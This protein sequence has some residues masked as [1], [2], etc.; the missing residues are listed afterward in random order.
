MNRTKNF[1]FNTFYTMLNSMVVMIVGFITPRL[2]L[3]YFGSEINGLVSSISQFVSYFNLVEAGLANASIVALYK[4]IA[5]K[6]FDGIN[7]VVSATKKYYYQSGYIFTGLV[8][9]LALLYPSFA[10][11]T[12]LSNVE[13]SLLVIFI[14]ANGFLN[15]FSLAKYRALLTAAQKV[16]V[17]SNAS[18]IYTILHTVIIVSGVYFEFSILAIYFMSIFAMISR[19]SIL[20]LY[21]K[22]YFPKVDF[23]S[24][25]NFTALNKRW[26]ALILQFTGLAQRSAP[27][28]I[29]TFFLSLGEVSIFAIYNMVVTGIQGIL[30]IFTNSLASGFGDLIAREDNKLLAKTYSQFELTYLMLIAIAYTATFNL[31]LPFVNLYTQ[32]VKDIN[33]DLPIFSIIIVL[34]SFLYIIKTPQ[35]MLINAAGHFKE[36]KV[37]SFIQALIIIIGGIILVQ[38]FGLMGVLIAMCLSNLYRLIDMFFYVPKYILNINYKKSFKNYLLL[39]SIMIVSQFLISTFFDWDINSIIHWILYAIVLVIVTAIITL[40]INYLFNKGDFCQVYERIKSMK[41]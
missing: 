1:A 34:N 6:D 35:G 9:M 36:T 11:T 31:M 16:Y 32:G 8:F 15:F 38:P 23:N 10:Q 33:Y 37:Q 24:E 14:G 22:R 19:N 20:H 27:T 41:L 28:L 26:D 29:I 39:I 12:E 7:G 5:N 2:L 25:P 13:M 4:P 17:V 3:V 30:G 18:T 40:L 21:V